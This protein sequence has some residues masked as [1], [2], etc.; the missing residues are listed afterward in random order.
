MEQKKKK[1][2]MLS[3]RIGT[4]LL[5]EMEEIA[6]RERMNKSDY[7][8]KAISDAMSFS[9][10]LRKNQTFLVDPKMMQYALN[11]MDDFDIEEYAI[12]SIKNGRSILKDFLNK[13]VSSTIVQKYLT[14]KVNIITGLLTYITQSI[15]GP[16]GQNWFRRVNFSCNGTAVSIRGTH[17]LGLRFSRFIAYYFK[18]FFEIFGYNEMAGKTIIHTDRIKLVFL[19]D[20]GDFDVSMLM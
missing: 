19:G 1:E 7:I 10:M 17:D 2:V 8:R 13:N 9:V 15:L 12:L 16:T 5:K 18:H 4:D 6:K 11:F 20:D 3:I 14:S